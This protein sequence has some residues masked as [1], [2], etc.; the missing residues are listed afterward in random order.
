MASRQLLFGW[1]A[2]LPKALHFPPSVLISPQVK[3]FTIPDRVASHAVES[4][5]PPMVRIPL[6]VES[7][8]ESLSSGNSTA[9]HAFPTIRPHATRL[10]WLSTFQKQVPDVQLTHIAAG[11]L[12]SLVALYSQQ[13]RESWL[14]GTGINSRGQLGALPGHN[15]HW[16]V[17]LHQV[18][19][20]IKAVQCGREHALV[21]VTHGG[22]QSDRM[23]RDYLYGCGSNAYGQLGDKSTNSPA[24]LGV[25]DQQLGDSSHPGFPPHTWPLHPL[26]LPNSPTSYADMACGLDHTI[27][28]LDDHRICSMGW[29]ADGQLGRGEKTQTLS[30]PGVIPRFSPHRIVKLA[31]RGDFTLALTEGHQVYVWGNSEYGQAMLGKRIDRILMPTLVPFNQPI[32]DIAA[33]GTHALV[34]TASG[35]M[36][37][38][39]Y[40]ALGLDPQGEQFETVIPT[41]IPWLKSNGIVVSVYCGLEYSACLTDDGKLFMWGLNSP[42]HR[43]DPVAPDATEHVY[44]PHPVIFKG[45]APTRGQVCVETVACGSHHVLARGHF[46]A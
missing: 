22:G 31:S 17:Q 29:G 39:G 10:D 5:A 42:F 40:G 18:T 4:R 44:Q 26:R 21:V 36:Y 20:R 25:P 9:E 35:E 13:R 23:E 41:R 14:L 3:P 46:S 28:Q 7:F 37:T 45:G 43:L 34:L 11:H 24:A 8:T 2:G 1:G 19:G 33:G 27:L 15:R 12:F 6:A 16:D 30:T 32:V 38:C